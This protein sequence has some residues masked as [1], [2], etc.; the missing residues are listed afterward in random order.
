M[1]VFGSD[2]TV[3][4]A[5][6]R[7]A[8]H[9]GDVVNV[10]VWVGGERDDRVQGARVELAC[11]NRFHQRERDYDSDGRSRDRTV[12]RE[13][14]FVAV[15]QPLP[16]APDGPVAFGE[17]TVQLQFPPDAPPTAFEP[18]GFGSMVR[19]EVRAI[20][21][22]R[23]GFD[24]DASIEV[25]V[26]SLPNQYAHWAQSPP[27]AKSHEVPM[28]LD[29]VSARILRPGSQ[30]TGV[31]HVQPSES[32]K[33]RSIRVQFERRRTDT[34]DN[35]ESTQS[36]P[37]VELARDVKL[38]AGQPLQ[39]PFQIPLPEG[40]PPTFAAAKSYMHWYL[41]GI[42][43]RKMRSDFVCECEVV[44]FT[45]AGE[46]QAV[47]QPQPGQVQ[48]VPVATGAQA[49]G[50]QLP[51]GVQPDPATFGRPGGAQPLASPPAPP[52]GAPAA[53]ARPGSF[54][55]DWYPDPWL[56]ARLRYWDGNAW[57]GHTA[58]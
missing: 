42:V 2:M 17:H 33:A 12:T 23:M 35:M 13:E 8:V 4:A 14:A 5:V 45:G 30:V 39:Y 29:Q 6:D 54:P 52:G 7:T 1:G 20:L 24:P 21:D 49:G 50:L 31:L 51:G 48:S 55:A 38:E 36:G 27:V 19:W 3:Q 58:E 9:P 44:V 43:D 40:V 37:E 26:Y 25:Q 15:W 16:G 11:I 46:P 22:R 28:T 53:E 41:E 32:V 18:E 47:Q 34:P 57:T 10:K 56:H